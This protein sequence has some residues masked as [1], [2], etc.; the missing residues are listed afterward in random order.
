VNNCNDKNILFSNNNIK[1]KKKNFIAFRPMFLTFVCIILALLIVDFY[2]INEYLAL[3]LLSIALISFLVFIFIKDYKI[4]AIIV[5][6]CIIS[7][8]VFAFQISNALSSYIVESQTYTV[9]GRTDGVINDDGKTKKFLLY[10]CNIILD[11]KIVA[12][13]KIIQAYMPS[14]SSLECGEKITFTANLSNVYVFDENSIVSYNA[15]NFVNY[16][17]YINTENILKREQTNLTLQENIKY[18]AYQNFINNMSNEGAGLAYAVFFGDKVFLEESVK[19]AFIES[20]LA[21][22]L[23]VSGLHTTLIFAIIIFLI[24]KLRI[25]FGY[26]ALI[27]GSILLLFSYLC[28]FTPSVVRASI[29]AIVLWLVQMIKLGTF[30]NVCVSVISGVGIY[31][32]TLIILKSE[33]LSYAIDL[34]KNKLKKE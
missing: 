16:S 17:C 34:I 2:F 6:L 9:E 31:F 24:G 19:T 28:G 32:A 30:I 7:S 21:H 3:T 20:G 10:N 27:A 26:K 14:S 22:I 12:E 5:V 29:M 8:C 18:H 13:N 25:K 1:E 15:Y 11:D 4:F 33:M 23:A